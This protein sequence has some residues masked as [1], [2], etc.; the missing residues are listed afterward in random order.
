MALGLLYKIENY[1]I[2][3]Q[4]PKP[5]L[6]LLVLYHPP[7]NLTAFSSLSGIDS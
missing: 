3:F 5:L 2:F 6:Q 7:H 4:I 1:K